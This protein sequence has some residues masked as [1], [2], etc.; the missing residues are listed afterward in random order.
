MIKSYDRVFGIYNISVATSLALEGATHTGEYEDA[1]ASEFPLRNKLLMVN[2]RTLFRN[3]INAFPTDT[4][5]RLTIGPIVDSVREDMEG[6]LTTLKSIE[7]ECEVKFY[8]CTYKKV[9]DRY[10]KANFYN[11]NTEKQ[12]HYRA[13]EE[14][15][16][17][18]LEK[19]IGG[20]LEV[21]EYEIDLDSNKPTV[22][23][24]HHPIDLLSAPNFPS[25][26]LLES[27]TGKVKGPSEWA[28]KLTNKPE[29][30]PFSKMTLTLFGDGVVFA[31]QP[32]K[33]RKLILELAKKYKWTYKT[34]DTRII[35]A[36]KRGYEPH[37]VKLLRE[38]KK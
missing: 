32:L 37:L 20:N 26:S 19:V 18:N 25:L 3:A 36:V 22:L 12:K 2:L 15:L 35:E 17:A 31:P 16:F 1:K 13:L 14:D 9:N 8:Y 27:H 30:I 34:P 10:P 33:F 21:T 38:L 28:S 4:Q 29:M 6:I 23:L 5:K 7:P 24:T 11:A